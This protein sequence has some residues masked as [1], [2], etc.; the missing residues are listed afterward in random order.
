MQITTA[1]WH[2]TRNTT[3]SHEQH[4]KIS[5][6]EGGRCLSV[7]AGAYGDYAE[8]L[9]SRDDFVELYV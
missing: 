3:D 7:S 2:L 9:L 6:A 5:G 4:F 1:A 8:G